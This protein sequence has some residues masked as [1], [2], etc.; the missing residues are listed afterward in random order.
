MKLNNEQQRGIKPAAKNYRM[1]AILSKSDNK[2]TIKQIG[3]FAL[4]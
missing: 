3:V 2:G 1:E 4:R